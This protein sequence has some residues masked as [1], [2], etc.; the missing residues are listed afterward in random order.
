MFIA[1]ITY[2]YINKQ[3][4]QLFKLRNFQDVA[5]KDLIPANLGFIKSFEPEGNRIWVLF[6]R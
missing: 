5:V 4:L 6:L 1:M 3:M 2:F